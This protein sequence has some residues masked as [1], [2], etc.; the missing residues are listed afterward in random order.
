M[1]DAVRQI[2]REMTV[3]M[4]ARGVQPTFDQFAAFAANRLDASAGDNTFSDKTGNCRLEWY[5]YL[6]RHP[7]EATGEAERFSRRLH[8]DATAVDGLP[9]LLDAAMVKLDV[10][11]DL[12]AKQSGL[13][14]QSPLDELKT[15]I[16]DARSLIDQAGTSLTAEE[17]TELRTNLYQQTTGGI[18]S[19]YRFADKDLGRRVCDLLEKLDRASLMRAANRLAFVA[20]AVPG[21]SR[22]SQAFISRMSEYQ[23]DRQMTEPGVTGPLANVITTDHGRI[24][25]AGPGD[26]V[27]EL[28]AMTDVC[29]VI[30]LGGNDTYI[31][32]TLSAE[33]PLLLIVDLAGNDTYRGVKP[34]IQGGAI[35]GVSMLVDVAGDDTYNA[36]DNAQGSSLG[37]VGV[38]VDMAG[39]DTYRGHRR[40][41]GQGLGGIGILIDRDGSDDYRGASL[42]QGVGG[43]LG[44]GVLDDLDGA[45]KYYAGGLYP[46]AYGDSPGFDGFSQGVGVGPRGV[47]NGGIGVLL[48]GGG[49]DVY[50]AGYFSH[51]GGYWFSA[52][53]ARDF[54]GNDKRYG[55]TLSDYD[56]SPS[57]QANFSRWGIGF[58]CHFAL[59]FIL[60]DDGDDLYAGTMAGVGFAWDLGYGVIVDLAG[61]DRYEA[62]NSGLAQAENAGLAIIYDGN[63]DDV[64][65]GASGWANPEVNY[66]E[67]ADAGGNFAFLIDR[68]G[69]NT[70][71]SRYGNDSL[72][73][74]GWAGGFM[75][76]A[77][78]SARPAVE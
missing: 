50:E 40:V 51:G 19:G 71:T 61:N 59:G 70:I 39:D 69:M 42:A 33:R 66:F 36:Q 38:L 25:I 63:G 53:I 11:V 31:E 76:S 21:D 72:Q 14:S 29:A 3:N 58:G 57:S 49:D 60:D 55:Y 35:L 62:T 73:E 4:A 16:A 26:H 45:D 17:W 74:R 6:L 9:R 54:A 56:G 30:D 34:G 15:A 65:A 12:P 24:L 78:S 7:M 8:D 67:K 20:E 48:D 13:R 2:E 52:G 37:G 22:G 77:V 44:L 41:Q 5:D 64:Y 68:K 32:G 43:P 27:Y 28:D 23:V 47:A 1:A 46:N 18:P 75:I 10:S